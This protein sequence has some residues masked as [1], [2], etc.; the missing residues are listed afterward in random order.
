MDWLYLEKTYAIYKMVLYIFNVD[1]DIWMFGI[2]NYNEYGKREVR[3]KLFK[4]SKRFIKRT[5]KKFLNNE[6]KE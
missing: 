3:G 5:N 6:L 1:T 4:K 2:A